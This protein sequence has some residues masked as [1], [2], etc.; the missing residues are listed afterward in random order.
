MRFL[1]GL[2]HRSDLE[3]DA[4]VIDAAAVL[5]G[6][7]VCAP[8]NV[9]RRY[10]P[11]FAVMAEGRIGPRLHDD[12]EVLFVK[13]LLQL[14]VTLGIG[15]AVRQALVV[16]AERVD[17]AWLVAARESGERPALGHLVENRDVFGNAQRVVA[18]QHQTQLPNP[19]VPGL[20]SQKHVQQDRIGGN[21]LALD[22]EM[23]LGKC[24]SVVTVLVEVTGLFGQVCE[25]S[26]IKIG[27]PARH[28]G[29]YLDLVADTRQV[30]Y[31]DFHS[32]PRKQWISQSDGQTL[33]QNAT[34][35]Y[36][37]KISF[38]KRA[39]LPPAIGNWPAASAAPRCAGLAARTGCIF[40]ASVR[41]PQP[42]RRLRRLTMSIRLRQIC[43]VAE[44]LAPVLDDLKAIFALDVC[45]VDPAVAAFGLENSLLP[46]GSNFLEVVA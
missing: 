16:L 30:K 2:R 12:V 37:E 46:V 8:K 26:L 33:A 17:P 21:F 15:L 4:L 41:Q 31:S 11:V 20:H 9:G 19:Q 29:A 22:V 40:L 14:L 28:A 44:K 39:I 45:F 36:Q 18:R 24:D 42:R 3:Q 43:L 7:V 35:R 6:N 38:P 23:M 25:H 10:L 34:A 32:S 13:L 27:T 5:A 1:I